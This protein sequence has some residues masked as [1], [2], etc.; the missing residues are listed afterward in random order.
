MS[1]YGEIYV[2]VNAD[3]VNT[4]IA[5]LSTSGNIGDGSTDGYYWLLWSYNVS[6]GTYISG[7]FTGISWYWGEANNYIEQ[8][9]NNS[10]LGD[11]G[12][13][14]FIQYL[15]DNPNLTNLDD[16]LGS[17]P[18]EEKSLFLETHKLDP[19]FGSCFTFIDPNL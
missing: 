12:Y 15:V 8:G 9:W 1:G 19:G 4:G 5:T 18:N 17:W 13:D 7:G 14:G 2:E 11:Q 10:G 6:D 3:V 16:I